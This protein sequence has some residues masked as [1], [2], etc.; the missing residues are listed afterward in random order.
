MP[1]HLLLQEDQSQISP[2]SPVGHAMAKLAASE[3]IPF[4]PYLSGREAVY[5]IALKAAD[6]GGFLRIKRQ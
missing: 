3:N 6:G 5:C 1:V 2:A 4:V